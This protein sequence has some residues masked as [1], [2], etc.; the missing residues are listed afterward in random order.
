MLIND[1]ARFCMIY[2][3]FLMGFASAFFVLFE[4]TG[5]GGFVSS[6]QRCFVAMLGDFDMDAFAETPYTAVTVGLL[7]VYVV[8]ITILLLN[9][10]IA[11]MGDTFDKARAIAT[12]RATHAIRRDATAHARAAWPWCTGT[13]W[14]HVFSLLSPH[15]S[16]LL[17]APPPALLCRSTKRP[18]C[19]GTWSVLGSC[20][21]SKT[22]CRRLSARVQQTNIGKYSS[23]MCAHCSEHGR[24]TRSASRLTP[25]AH[26]LCVAP[27]A[28]VSRTEI[29]GQR[30]LQVLEV[31]PNHFKTQAD[32][33]VAAAAAKATP[34]KAGDE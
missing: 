12:T 18:R 14:M 11:M 33:T 17:G 9:L 7:V 5:F 32:P 13:R 31:N 4:S 22:K 21:P 29:G 8:T 25:D 3:V 27:A 24:R 30:F 6:V 23:V 19:S 2:L 15:S 34:A 16:L 20:S 26:L 1:V 28:S 10:L